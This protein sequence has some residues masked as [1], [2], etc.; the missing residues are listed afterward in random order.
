MKIEDL[1]PDP[2]W[3]RIK[4]KIP[5]RRTTRKG[6]RPAF[7]DRRILLGILYVLKSGIPWSMLPQEMGCGSG[8]TCWRRLDRWQKAGVWEKVHLLLLKELNK[9]GKINWKRGAI[10]GSNVR[11]LFGG[12]K[13]VPILQTKPKPGAKEVF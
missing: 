11:A 10:D 5:K 3:E 1:L 9:A 12:P 8:M 6:G 7:D 2:L 4:A 13:R